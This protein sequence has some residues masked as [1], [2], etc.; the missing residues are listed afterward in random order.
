MNMTPFCTTQVLPFTTTIF[1]SNTAPVLHQQP[2]GHK[3]LLFSNTTLYCK[4]RFNRTFNHSVLPCTTR[5]SSSTNMY[6]KSQR[7]YY[8]GCTTN[9]LKEVFEQQ[10]GILEQNILLVHGNSRVLYFA[11]HSKVC[12]KMM[13]TTNYLSKS[14][15]YQFYF[16]TVEAHDDIFKCNNPDQIRGMKTN[17]LTCG[18]GILE[19]FRVQMGETETSCLGSGGKFQCAFCFTNNISSTF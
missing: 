15:L 4:T 7:Q 18:Q 1:Y 2:A 8:L 17:P 12:S 6:F 11:V 19:N 10:F 14:P 13:L 5:R 9:V 16:A 3:S